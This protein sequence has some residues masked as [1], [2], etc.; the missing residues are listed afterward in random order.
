MSTAGT[1]SLG[2]VEHVDRLEPDDEPLGVAV[3]VET[4]D[5]DR[6]QDADGTPWG[7]WVYARGFPPFDGT[8]RERESP[9]DKW[10][11][12]LGAPPRTSAAGP[13]ELAAETPFTS[14]SAPV[15]AASSRYRATSPFA[16]R[17][18]RV[19]SVKRWFPTTMV[20]RICT[21]AWRR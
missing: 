20:S 12:P 19:W 16:G 7:W 18:M 1:A 8:R 2:D 15:L 13:P 6:G 3:R 9:S 21:T 10:A 5:R 11:P 4:L 14:A 17:T